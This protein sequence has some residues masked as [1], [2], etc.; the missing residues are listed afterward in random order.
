MI[1]DKVL[2]TQINTILTV[3]RLTKDKDNKY[4]L[5]D[6]SAKRL[7]LSLLENMNSFTFITGNYKE[8][9]ANVNE[10]LSIL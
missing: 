4:V 2:H 9:V 10:S 1:K 8:Y 5:D 3:I 6:E 7:T